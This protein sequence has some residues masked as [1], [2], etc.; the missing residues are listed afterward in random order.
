MEQVEGW[1]CSRVGQGGVQ[2][3]RPWRQDQELS[4][5]VGGGNAHSTVMWRCWEGN[6]ICKYRIWGAV[7]TGEIKLRVF[8]ICVIFKVTVLNEVI[9]GMSLDRQEE[10]YTSEKQS[11]E[12]DWYYVRYVRTFRI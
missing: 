6:W 7:Q 12:E 11:H 2:A 8:R 10:V 4:E 1:K 9:K 3:G 5:D